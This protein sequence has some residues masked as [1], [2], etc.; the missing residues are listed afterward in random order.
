VIY[1]SADSDI[2]GPEV[3]AFVG[4]LVFV[5]FLVGAA[6]ATFL[7]LRKTKVDAKQDEDMRQLVSRY[8]RLAENTL[9][10]QQRTAADVAEL[11]TRTAAVEQIL[12]S[13]E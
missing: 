9:D 2:S 6:C 7:E 12:R 1:L 13:V 10:A 4:L 11:R 5:M 3:A 8:E